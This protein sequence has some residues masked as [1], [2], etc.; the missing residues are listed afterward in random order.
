[1]S[2]YLWVTMGLVAKGLEMEREQALLD[3]DEDASEIDDEG[4]ALGQTAAASTT[5]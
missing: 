2:G 5:A 4:A 1:V 3:E